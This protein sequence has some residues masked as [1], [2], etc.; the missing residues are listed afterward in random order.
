M[1]KNRI[2]KVLRDRH[3]FLEDYIKSNLPSIHYRKSIKGR[4]K[5]T[6]SILDYELPEELKKNSI[7]F[8]RDFTKDRISLLW[9]RA[10]VATN[11]IEDPRY[12]PEDI[13]YKTIEPRLNRFDLANGYEDKNLYDK[14]FRNVKMP[15]TV[16][17]NINGNYYNHEYQSISLNEAKEILKNICRNKKLVCKPS[18]E[19][20]GGKKIEIINLLGN[21]NNNPDE[22][23]DNT[24]SSLERDFIIQEYLEQHKIFMNMHRDSLNTIRIISLRLNGKIYYLSG[25]V[26]M[27]NNGSAVD[28]ATVGGLTCGFNLEGKLNSFATGHYA[29]DK[30]P[31][32]PF[33]KFSFEGAA[34][35]KMELIVEFV[36]ELHSRLLYFDIAS[37]DI[38]IDKVGE[39]VLIEV[40]LRMQ[41]I[42]FHQR[43]NGPLFGDITVEVLEEVFGKE[44]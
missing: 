31:F 10:Y 8:W 6:K 28:N 26:R 3:G 30:F 1:D 43:N 19:S 17:R 41:D 2:K 7:K 25:I 14:L 29:Y 13:F 37:W 33:S 32:H 44:K 21:T 39:P 42:N 27:G 11:S 9:H 40:N 36:K 12:V 5:K 22:I 16:I 15:V 23:I 35:P 38:A 18:I 20:G 4:I 34:I 24:F